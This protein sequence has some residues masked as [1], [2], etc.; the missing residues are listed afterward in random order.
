MGC[1]PQT[2]KIIEVIKVFE[3]APLIS[4]HNIENT[5]TNNG[6]EI[7]RKKNILKPFSDSW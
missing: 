3:I 5:K 1:T 7:T 2:N 4:L 6:N